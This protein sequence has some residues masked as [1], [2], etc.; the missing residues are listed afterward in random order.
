MTKP[1]RRQLT[2]ASGSGIQHYAFSY[3]ATP[4]HTYVLETAVAAT[5]TTDPI[6]NITLQYQM[7]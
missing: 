1:R 6:V 3:A 4:A 7:Q 2:L 5:C